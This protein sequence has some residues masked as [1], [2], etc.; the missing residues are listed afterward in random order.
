MTKNLQGKE[1]QSVLQDWVCNLPLRMQGTLL[2]A[3]RGCDLTPKLPLDS[4]ERNLVAFI[5]CAVMNPFDER[6]I[7]F[8]VGC[9]MQSRID[10]NKFRPSQFG[11]YP[12]H[13]VS[14]LIHALQIIG[15]C[16]YGNMQCDAKRAYLQ[17]VKALHLNIETLD[18][19][20]ERLTEDRILLNNVVG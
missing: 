2:T 11:H 6:E 19:M 13:Y 12:Q 8:E 5:R 15:Y 17:F 18:E 10:F 4:T 7:D 14:H 9:F 20:Y 1:F 16:S 3:I